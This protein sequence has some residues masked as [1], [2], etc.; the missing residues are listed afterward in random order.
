MS[1]ILIIF[2]IV[3]FVLI[4]PALMR[5]LQP[6]VKSDQITIEPKIERVKPK[7][8]PVGKMAPHT[9]QRTLP[10][11]F[12]IHPDIESRDYRRAIESRTLA[13]HID[14]HFRAEVT[15]EAFQEHHPKKI[16]R[17]SQR[18]LKG[19]PLKKMVI[20]SLF[21]QRPRAEN[22]YDAER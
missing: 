17:A 1:S 16:R 2:F 13:T 8:E 12:E 3:L 19:P 4:F 10:S 22:P 21:L 7:K 9:T 14:P 11:D 20:Y 6:K 15:S 5:F 18:G